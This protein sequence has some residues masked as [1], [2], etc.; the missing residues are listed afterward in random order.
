MITVSLYFTPKLFGKSISVRVDSPKNQQE[1]KV[2]FA[3][4]YRKIS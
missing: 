3:N 4:D 1:K 2:N